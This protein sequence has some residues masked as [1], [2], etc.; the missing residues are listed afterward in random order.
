MGRG[1][2]IKSILKKVV[3]KNIGCTDDQMVTLSSLPENGERKLYKINTE[4]GSGKEY[5][6]HR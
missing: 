3:E 5:R 4:K 2:F 1:N 6:M